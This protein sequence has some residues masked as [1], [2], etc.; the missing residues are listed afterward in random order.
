MRSCMYCLRHMSHTL[1]MCVW[2]FPKS[3]PAEEA[4]MLARSGLHSPNPQSCQLFYRMGKD[5]A[6]SYTVSFAFPLA[7]W[8]V[9]GGAAFA[10]IITLM[11]F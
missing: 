7:V 1:L 3:S 4:K 8:R 10:S 5:W 11:C 2:S 9:P 6:Y